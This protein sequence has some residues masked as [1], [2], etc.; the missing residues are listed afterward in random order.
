MSEILET[1]TSNLTAFLR[2]LSDPAPKTELVDDP[3]GRGGS[4]L[5]VRDDYKVEQV[6]G[7][8]RAKR[9]HI[10][11]DLR[12]FAEWLKRWGKPDTTEILVG[13]AKARALLGG[14]TVAHD[15]ASDVSCVLRDHPTFAA[16]RKAFGVKMNPKTFHA[17][18]RSVAATFGSGGGG[19][20][21]A[22]VLS[23][24]LAKLKAVKNGEINM[25]VDPRGFYAVSGASTTTQ[26]DAKIPPQFT[27]RTPILIGIPESE[28]SDTEMLYG[29]EILLSMDVED[30]GI[31]FTLTCPTL[32]AVLHQARL[33]AVGYLRALLDEGFLVGLG[34]IAT[35]TVAG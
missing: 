25:S 28:S 22:D 17:F 24:E 18:I 4:V 7:P 26:V 14:A 12:S 32:D 6:A 21:A 9:V 8:D 10:F 13:D 31:F 27:V 23:G 30:S 15:P 3:N 20:T 33:D 16:W 19:V 29:L 2:L 1:I 5:I 35:I 11:H 34:D